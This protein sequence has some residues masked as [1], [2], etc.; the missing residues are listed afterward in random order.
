M[1]TPVLKCVK[2]PQY[3]VS[4]FAQSNFICVSVYVVVCELCHS[5]L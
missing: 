3:A 5:G 4:E 1:S 2:D